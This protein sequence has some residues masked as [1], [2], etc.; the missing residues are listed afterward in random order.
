MV[1]GDRHWVPEMDAIIF[2]VEAVDTSGDATPQV[3][4]YYTDTKILE[5][6]TSDYGVENK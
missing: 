6:L 2:T 5:Q 1:E 3:F 4:L